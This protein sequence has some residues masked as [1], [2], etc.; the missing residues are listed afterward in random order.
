M[1]AL[2]TG[3]TPRREP[4]RTVALSVRVF[5][6]DA[7]GQPVNC[8]CSTVDIS[9]HGVRLLGVSHWKPGEVIGIRHGSEK[10]RFKI[11]WI[12]DPGSHAEAQ[13]GL[14]AVEVGRHFWGLNMPQFPNSPPA[15]TAIG[16]RIG[17]I[18]D[19]TPKPGRLNATSTS[20]PQADTRRHS[21]LRCNGG[22]KIVSGGNQHWA[23]VIDISSGGC[24]LE[25]PSTYPVGQLMFLKLGVEGLILESDA[26]V[27]VSHP[28]MGMGVEF[29]RLSA[30]LRVRLEDFVA[31]LSRDPNRLR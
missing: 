18:I 16:S 13:I 5:G 14:Q 4:R 17:G 10:G 20:M 25:C 11:V 9:A 27:R 12:G 6:L 3:A 23:T 28:G 22:A 7:S 21:R 24:Y 1:A 2:S 30:M 29:M 19:G 8:E 31:E 15:T 26:V